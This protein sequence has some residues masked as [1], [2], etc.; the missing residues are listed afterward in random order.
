MQYRRE[1]LKFIAVPVLFCCL[2]DMMIQ[3]IQLNL[4]LITKNMRIVFLS[5]S[6][7]ALVDALLFIM[8]K[9]KESKNG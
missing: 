3:M 6:E 2:I 8:E 1:N 5:R 7:Q 4:I 9:E